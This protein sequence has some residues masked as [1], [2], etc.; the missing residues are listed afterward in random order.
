MGAFEVFVEGCARRFDVLPAVLVLVKDQPGWDLD[1][2]A[3]A[4]IQPQLEVSEP[5]CMKEDP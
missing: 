4:T 3:I 2:S 5:Y 1:G